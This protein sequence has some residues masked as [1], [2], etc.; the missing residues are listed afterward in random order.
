M[1]LVPNITWYH[2]I[3]LLDIFLTANFAEVQNVIKI[4]KKLQ[5]LT[6][7]GQ[8]HGMAVYN[9]IDCSDTK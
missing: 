7:G 6:L 3:Q 8:L 1:I 5:F 9:I 2:E 4:K